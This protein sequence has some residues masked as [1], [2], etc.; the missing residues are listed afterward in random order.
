MINYSGIKGNIFLYKIDRVCLG[1][2]ILSDYFRVSRY[3]MVLD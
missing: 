1:F 3:L 2:K